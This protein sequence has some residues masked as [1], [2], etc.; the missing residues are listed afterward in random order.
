ML[1]LRARHFARAFLGGWKPVLALHLCVMALVGGCHSSSGPYAPTA[2]LT[3]I[4]VG[5]PDSS[6]AMGL[7]S[8]F[9]AT[10]L[11]S[12]GSKQDISAQV[13]WSSANA[14]AASISSAGLATAASPGSTMITAKMGKMSGSTSFNVTPATLVVID[15]TPTNASIANGLT[16]R[17]VAAGVFTDNSVH[18]ISASVTWSSSVA[19]VAAVSNTSGSNGM[20]TTAG[21]GSTMITATL[22]TVSAST[23]LTVTAATLVSI[24]VTPTSPSIANG[25]SVALHATGIYTDHS[26]HDL[27][28]SVSWSSSVASVASVS[29]LPGSNGLATTLS[30]GS[31]AITATLGGISGSTNLTVTAATLVS[32]GVTPANPSIA[33]GLK[34]Q[35]TATGTYTDNSTQILT[36]QVDWSSSDQ[37]VASVSNALGYDGLG[38]GLNPGSVTITATLGGAW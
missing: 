1:L 24:E 4:A 11:Y 3:S 8:Q 25:L 36:A 31:T 20:I 13:T 19:T 32:L 22:G 14:A 34:S 26:T 21:P 9:T 37:T 33:K 6:V 10:G 27:T 28:S 17:F 2:Q 16:G 30:P 29:N 18:D 35:F 38:V 5:P 7:T 15:L 23:T 12:D